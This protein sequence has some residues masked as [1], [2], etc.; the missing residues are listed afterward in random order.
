M[1][2]E[3]CGTAKG[4]TWE[5]R[6]SQA[7]AQRGAQR[8]P[9]NQACE[10][11]NLHKGPNSTV[12]DRAARAAPIATGLETST[13][14][15][16]E[17]EQWVFELVTRA[18]DHQRSSWKGSCI[19]CLH[20]AY[21]FALGAMC[22]AVSRAVPLPRHPG[23]LQAGAWIPWPQQWFRHRRKALGRKHWVVQLA[24]WLSEPQFFSTRRSMWFACCGRFYFR[25]TNAYASCVFLRPPVGPHAGRISNSA[26]C[27]RRGMANFNMSFAS[28]IL[29]R[30]WSVGI[31]PCE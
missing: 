9:G 2:W 28:Q 6:K 10:S 30:L 8:L 25:R 12:D 27:G 21:G 11:E 13:A 20:F 24:A 5:P 3:A 23:N 1:A 19:V 17:Q 4:E 31:R 15:Q 22:V 14:R 18:V 16:F 7:C 29:P 26:L